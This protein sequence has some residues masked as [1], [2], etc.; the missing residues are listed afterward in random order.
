MNAIDWFVIFS[1][2]IA[3]LH[4]AYRGFIKEAIHLLAWLI[5][6]FAAWHL[7]RFFE[8]ALGG[9]LA[10]PVPRLWAARACVL[11]I[12]LSV[13]AVAGTTTAHH[14]KPEQLAA[15]DGALGAGVSALRGLLIF[16]V[17]VLV[18]QV[19]HLD[20]ESWWQK[21]RLIPY[22]EAVANGVRILVG[23]ERPHHRRVVDTHHRR[24]VY[25]IDRPA[26]RRP[27]K[28]A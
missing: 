9:L 14:V 4:G 1:V 3:A 16:G 17:L 19:L 27:A 6:L 2:G 11:L 25:L 22:G 13:G 10:A 23:E 21:S 20:G 15:I 12:A 26:Q 8:P 7:G 24:M 28:A 5:G 18:G